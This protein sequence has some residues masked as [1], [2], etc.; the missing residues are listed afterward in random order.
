MNGM[1]HDSEEVVVPGDEDEIQTEEQKQQISKIKDLRLKQ[2]KSEEF[3]SLDSAA[4]SEP[5]IDS[6]SLNSLEA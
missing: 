6:F 2:R 5:K 1:G 4:K 3:I